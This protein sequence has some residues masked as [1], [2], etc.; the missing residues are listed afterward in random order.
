MSSFLTE[1]FRVWPRWRLG[2]RLDV[3]MEVADMYC[4]YGPRQLGVLE[5]DT[6]GF[7]VAD[8]NGLSK[9]YSASP[10][11][12][13]PSWLH[14]ALP[15]PILVA[16]LLCGYRCRFTGPDP[17]LV[18]DLI[19]QEVSLPVRPRG[20]DPPAKD[21]TP[22]AICAIPSTVAAFAVV[23][24]GLRNP[25]QEQIRA[26]VDHASGRA[27]QLHIGPVRDGEVTTGAGYPGWCRTPAPCGAGA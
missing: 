5:H 22:V 27:Q 12:A 11:T 10:A 24:V 7:R 19:L 13:L 25:T 17:I 21:S 20:K 18:C 26:W 2:W 9:L 16:L 15:V 6:T 1:R 23:Y 8:N 14:A 4:T 3:A